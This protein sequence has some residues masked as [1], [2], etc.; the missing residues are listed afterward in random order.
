[1]LAMLF[2]VIPTAPA[3]VGG[4]ET[5]YLPKAG[6]LCATV[7]V[8]GMTD[9]PLGA[10]VG[11]ADGLSSPSLSSADAV[12]S[13]SPPT[14]VGGEEA[15]P[16]S[17]LPSSGKTTGPVH[18]TSSPPSPNPLSRKAVYVSLYSGVLNGSSS[19][20]SNVQ[21]APPFRQKLSATTKVK[22]TSGP[23]VVDK[24]IDLSFVNI[25]HFSAVMHP[26]EHETLVEM[27]V[28]MAKFAN[29]N[30]DSVRYFQTT[31]F[32]HLH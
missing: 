4:L 15:V 22:D 11:I 32:T 10:E 18:V 29:V 5:M 1:M 24:F 17:L 27:D 3:V 7:N 28:S 13:G 19:I 20:F 31:D 23:V 6:G 14:V 9:P 8:V 21:D 25:T 30:V 12:G 16:P 2:D 26:Q